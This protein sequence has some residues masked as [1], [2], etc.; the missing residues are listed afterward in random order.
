MYDELVQLAGDKPV[1]ITEGGEVPDLAVLPATQP[2]YSFYMIWGDH[3]WKN[4]AE[5]ITE[6]VQH[7][8]NV[9]QG[10]LGL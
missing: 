6:S 4:S 1:G 5:R 8:R 7:P 10:E 3:V 9:S 2:R